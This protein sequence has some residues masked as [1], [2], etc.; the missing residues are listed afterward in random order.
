MIE[1][2]G[3]VEGHRYEEKEMT[4]YTDGNTMTSE[5]TIFRM[6]FNENGIYSIDRRAIEDT[7][8]SLTDSAGDLIEEWSVKN[9]NHGG[10][11]HTVEN[12]EFEEQ[13]GLEVVSA[14]GRYGAAVMPGSIVKYN[15]EYRNNG[16][17]EKDI[18][19]AVRLDS[20][21]EFMPANSS[22]GGREMNG[23]VT[24]VVPAVEPEER[25]TI[26]VTAAVS[27]QAETEILSHA[28][29]G[30]NDYSC[31]NPVASEGTLTI[32]TRVSGTASE[33]LRKME[34]DYEILLTD[35]S[36]VPLKGYCQYT[37]SKEGRI[38]SGEQISLKG[39]E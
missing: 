1:A 6:H 22:A 7:K 23:I 25:G 28:S 5:R 17:A 30:T 34:C 21:L 31:L 3:L 9:A 39:G 19:I 4:K 33:E 15:I 2:D 35:A 12:P 24:W 13:Q 8:L 37:G 32:A 20:Q 27:E 14:N 29:I 26:T 36:G 16:K 10:Y 18:R 38:K 11:S